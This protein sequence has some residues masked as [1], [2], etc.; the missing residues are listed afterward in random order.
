ML[1]ENTIKMEALKIAGIEKMAIYK[2]MEHIL[3]NQHID[4]SDEELFAELEQ[5]Y[6]EN[7]LNNFYNWLKANEENFEWDLSSKTP[8]DLTGIQYITVY[9]N[10]EYPNFF[11]ETGTITY[12]NLYINI[13]EARNLYLGNGCQAIIAFGGGSPMDC[14]KVA[15]ARIAKPKKTVQQMRGTL[16]ILKKLPTIYAVPTT[17]GT[18]SETTLSR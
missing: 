9:P 18:G 8:S 6:G 3:N 1:L 4:I 16:K 15:A 14:A 7:I 17:A 10:F 11:F 13:E 5:I 2:A 12:D